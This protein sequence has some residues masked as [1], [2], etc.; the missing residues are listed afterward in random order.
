MVTYS[1]LSLGSRRCRNDACTNSI[2]GIARTTCRC[3]TRL[4]R[5]SYP[6]HESSSANFSFRLVSNSRHETIDLIALPQRRPP[7]YVKLFA[8]YSERYN[9]IVQLMAFGLTKYPHLRRDL[10]TCCGVAER[11]RRSTTS[12][13]QHLQGREKYVSE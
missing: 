7:F 11:W 1:F 2:D 13:A 12:R 10:S 8:L 5:R 3:A 4:L 9:N 6:R